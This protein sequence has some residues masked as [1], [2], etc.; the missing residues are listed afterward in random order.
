MKK[1]NFKNVIYEQIE[2]EETL[3]KYIAKTNNIDVKEGKCLN[4]SFLISKK[5]P[6][7]SMVEG[8]LITYFEDGEIES[9]GHVWNEIDGI[10]FDE[11]VDLKKTDKKII[12]IEYYLAD[13]YASSDISTE[14]R[15]KPTVG[16]SSFFEKPILEKHMIFKTNVKKLEIELKEF[17]NNTDDKKE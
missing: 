10:Y 5:F 9:V 14:I 4:N 13:K 6:E 3:Q 16:L 2:R 8:F 12:K 11:T 15:E 17:L 1:L 7:V